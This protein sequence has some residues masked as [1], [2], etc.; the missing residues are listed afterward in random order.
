MKAPDKTAWHSAAG[1]ASASPGIGPPVRAPQPLT[2]VVP[3]A[4][5]GTR[6]DVWVARH[7]PGL[8][9]SRVQ[10]LIRAGAIRVRGRR[11]KPH[12]PLPGGSSLTIEIPAAVG[13]ELAPEPIPVDILH[14]DD[15]IVVVNKPAGLVVHPAAGHP[16]GT[17][18]NALLYHCR[19]LPGIAGERRPGIVHRLDKNTSG[20]MVVAKHDAAMAGLVA[21]FKAGAVR[22]EYL[23]LV[24]G[25]PKP[26]VGRLE[27]LIGRSTQD[28]KKMSATPKTGRTGVTRYEVL[29]HFAA[30]VSLLRV[31]IETGRTHQ[32][33]VHMAFMGHPVLGDAQYGTGRRTCSPVRVQRQMLHALRLGLT[34]PGS[35][36]PLQFLAP[37]PADMEEVLRRLRE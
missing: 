25:L 34:H 15:D 18:V 17:L 26:A 12:Y 19:V 7:A 35:G 33:R 8:S 37:V 24:W 20:V 21:Q 6:L 1:E 4:D 11:Q 28:R 14:E 29:E 31:R 5:A 10:A 13:T 9:R 27:T 22:K 30:G 36:K 32:I 3:E 16:A 2:F 23:A